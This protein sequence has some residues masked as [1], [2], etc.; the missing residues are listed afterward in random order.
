MHFASSQGFFFVTYT[1]KWSSIMQ[2]QYFTCMKITSPLL[3]RGGCVTLSSTDTRQRHSFS[4]S[5]QHEQRYIQ[6]NL[7]CGSSQNS[8]GATQCATR[9]KTG[10]HFQCLRQRLD[11][12]LNPDYVQIHCSE[13]HDLHKGF[14]K[15]LAHTS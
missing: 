1:Y 4:L 2:A 12:R 3:W 7:T 10:R 13:R 9:V 11:F 8:T 5:R 15:T 6:S 14:Y